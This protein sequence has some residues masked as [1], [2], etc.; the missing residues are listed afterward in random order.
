MSRERALLLQAR[1]RD[2]RAW[3]GYT[4]A[5]KDD[6]CS[7]DDIFSSANVADDVPEFDLYREEK[8]RWGQTSSSCVPSLDLTSGRGS[9]GFFWAAW[10]GY[11]CFK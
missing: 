2:V 10:A 9:L 7:G 6:T 3:D 1:S 8:E 11:I 4:N 5:A